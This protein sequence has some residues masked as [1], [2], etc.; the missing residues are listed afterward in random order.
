MTTVL[1]PGGTP[2]PTYNRSGKT[3]QS[4]TGVINAG[5]LSA[6]ASPT[7]YSERDIVLFTPVTVG[8]S[9]NS[10]AHMLLPLGCDIGDVVEVYIASGTANGYVSAGIGETLLGVSPVFQSNAGAPIF[11]GPGSGSTP[12]GAVFTKISS[13]N[14]QVRL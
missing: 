7:H 6:Y 8:D 5:S 13:T 2:S 3:I 12:V 10:G 1:D 9:S 14:W 4:L 11:A